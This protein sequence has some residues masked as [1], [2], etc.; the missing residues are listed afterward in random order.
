M[1]RVMQVIYPSV[2][3]HEKQMGFISETIT[4]HSTAEEKLKK[5]RN[6]V[7]SHYYSAYFLVYF[8][9]IMFYSFFKLF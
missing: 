9:F 2:T 4:F 1:A 3:V 5:E 8:F 6:D 7:N